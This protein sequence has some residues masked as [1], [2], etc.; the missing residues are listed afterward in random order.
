MPGQLRGQ[1]AGKLG[2]PLHHGPHALGGVGLG[3]DGGQWR[4]L[5]GGAASVQQ[6]ADRLPISRLMLCGGTS[7]AVRPCGP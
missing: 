3:G 6:I 2:S 1:R 5:G 4:L 7:G